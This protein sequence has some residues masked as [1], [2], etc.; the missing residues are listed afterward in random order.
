M[1][2]PI[3]TRILSEA[4]Y[5][6]V[7]VYNGWHDIFFVFGTLNL[8]YAVYNNAMLKYKNDIDG[9]TS[10]MIILIDT[11]STAFFAVYCVFSHFWEN[12]F[13]L[14]PILLKIIFVELV[15]VPAYSFWMSK[16][17]FFFQ[18]KKVVIVTLIVSIMSPVLSLFLISMARD[19]ATAKIMGTAL[20]TILIGGMLSI[21]FLYKGK[22]YVNIEY[23]TYAL[24]FNIPL[25]PH[26]LSGSV[27]NQSDRI[28]ISR[29]I[30]DAKAGIYSVAY[31]ASFTISILTTAIN[32]SLVP[33]IYDQ[34]E[35]GRYENIKKRTSIVLSA[36]AALLLLFM[37]VIPEFIT[38][39]AP[40]S[41]REAIN[42]LPILVMSVFFQFLYGF[43]GTVEFYYEKSIY[44]MLA[45]VIAASINIFTNIC[46]IPRFGY[47]AAAYTTLFCFIVM[48]CTHQLFL[49][50]ILKKHNITSDIFDIKQIIFI[51]G[52][53]LGVGFL[54]FI[55]YK[56]IL[57]RYTIVVLICTI[58]LFKYEKIVRIF[59]NR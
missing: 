7:S 21:N 3:F 55:L 34:M 14:S 22:R 12:V 51:S 36:F 59:C 17:R 56:N 37:L 44:V 52:L 29:L 42:I 20:P 57:I 39:L 45:S 11:I 13:D 1:T 48:S 49:R 28:M 10:S 26:Y 32:N 6:I 54:E 53:F 27:L 47:H 31:N 19:Q 41:Y 40:P 33:W 25:I 5:G 4:D 38:I 9:Y 50:I 8:F 2:V 24:K 43:F 23:W 58:V 46:F 16:Q 35:G 30:S 18:Y 15:T